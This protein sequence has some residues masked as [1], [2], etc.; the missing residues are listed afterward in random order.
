MALVTDLMGLGMSPYLANRIATQPTALTAGGASSGSAT[1]MGP[2]GLFYVNATNSGSGVKLPAV[3]GDPGCLLGDDVI[4]TN[5]LIDTV[6]VYIANNAAGSVCTLYI[7]GASVTGTTGVSVSG[8]KS[9]CFYPL[10]V[11]TWI[12]FRSASA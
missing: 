8:G 3:G 1:Q 9:V 4:L 12:G 11:S 2:N 6:Q 10:T 5:I 7:D